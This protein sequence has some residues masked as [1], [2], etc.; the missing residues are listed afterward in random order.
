[1]QHTPDEQERQ[2]KFRAFFTT[3]VAQVPEEMAHRDEA[4]EDAPTESRKITSGMLGRFFHKKEEPEHAAPAQNT[5][6]TPKTAAESNDPTGEVRLN[7]DSVTGEVRLQ[8]V[9]PAD[10]Q[11]VPQ[12]QPAPAEQPRPAAPTTAP[13]PQAAAEPTRKP[14]KK[15]MLREEEQEAQELRQFKELLAG[16]QTAQKSPEPAAPAEPTKAAHVA[17]PAP[18]VT[19]QPVAAQND[20]PELLLV[21]P[22]LT[23]PD[24]TPQKARA[25]DE[26]TTKRWTLPI[27]MP[28]Q[29]EPVPPEAAA[30]PTVQVLVSGPPL[31]NAAASAQ[32]EP[33]AKAA[34]DTDTLSLP[35]VGLEEEPEAPS[36]QAAAQAA[37][38]E[39]AQAAAE[40]AQTENVAE[41]A[42][43]AQPQ[44]EEDIGQTLKTMRARMTLRCVLSGIL[45]A[46]LLVLCL[47]AEGLLPATEALD[48]VFAPTAF[49]G[50]NL[51]VLVLALLVSFGVVRDGL[52]GLV[53]QPTSSSLPAIAA[54]AALVQS[55]AALLNATQYRPAG[56][57][58]MSGMAALGLFMDALG[59]RLRMEAIHSN[60][61]LLSGGVEYQG[62]YRVRDRDLVRCLADGTEEKEPWILLSRPVEGTSDFMEQ[63]FSERSDEVA[64]QRMARL[65]LGCGLLSGLVVLILGR[66]AAAAASAF[67]ATV[68]LGVPLSAT[69]LHGVTSLRMQRTAGTVGAVI[70]G[71]AAV[72]ELGGIDTVE[73]DS[74]ALFTPESVR[75][76]DIRIFKGGRID[77]AIL[78]TASLLYE[79]CNTLS[80]LFRQIIEDRT[81]IL[82]PIKDLEKR[83]G[84]GFAAWCDNC[85]VLVGTRE[86]ME[87][88]GV[89]MPDLA[90]ENERS[91]NGRLQVLYLAVSG[92]LHAMFLLRYVGGR[93][94]ARGLNVLQNENIRLL[95][96]CE[97]PTLT[98][99]RVNEVYRLPD[100]LVRVL[101]DDQC[102]MLAPALSHA[103]KIP[104]CM[105][106][107][108]GF[109]SLTGGVRAAAK[110][111]EAEKFG[112]SVQRVSVLISVLI[113]LLLT[114]AGS[115]GQLSIAAVLMYQAAWS[116]LSL[117]LAAMKQH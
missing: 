5:S 18:R 105:L 29:S 85:R 106:H 17:T 89:P 51:L 8:P 74:S 27:R 66:G 32:P 102:Q 43:E 83:R 39:L 2:E 10:L 60:Y 103:A 108:R 112:V 69:L 77:K 73:M 21:K 3:S 24:T 46:A 33:Q 99:A 48:P 63:S 76:E 116:A 52:V 100:G 54:V 7:F 56:L 94:T 97:D 34:E 86:M 53:D 93:N 79:G 16:M 113:A 81:D 40:P 9:D 70:P 96:S 4:R 47:M 82:L 101:N 84:L 92:N 42:A 91:Q 6:E 25:E 109:A 38:A 114:Y 45:A 49:M 115:V 22:D 59:S 12:A 68:C 35:L 61:T 50:A 78:Y 37:E 72:E 41:P 65:L 64:A 98:A 13:A 20:E 90:Y 1:M 57:S 80:G 30:Q 28:A 58:L 19:R 111:Q 26:A 67:A 107:L 71:W 95:L 15:P 62:A 117:V 104:C 14:E 88:E 110:A 75:L 55:V 23:A 11:N 31:P 87:Q 44:R 36:R